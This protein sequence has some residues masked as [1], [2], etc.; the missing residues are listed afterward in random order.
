MDE[1]KQLTDSAELVGKTIA[2]ACG[3]KGGGTNGL[4][5]DDGSFVLVHCEVDDDEGVAVIDDV[6][7]TFWELATLGLITDEERDARRR[8]ESEARIARAEAAERA[9]YE[10]L[11]ARFEPAPTPGA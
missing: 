3:F 7:A 4:V 8:A 10:R 1:P 9:T 11:K 2:R 5:F 6:D